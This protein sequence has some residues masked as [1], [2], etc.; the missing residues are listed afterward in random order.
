MYV[1]NIRVHSVI[2]VKGIDICKSGLLSHT[3]A[4]CTIYDTYTVGSSNVLAFI[5]AVTYADHEDMN[6]CFINI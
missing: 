1:D 6:V 3:N 5:V 2:L 4:L